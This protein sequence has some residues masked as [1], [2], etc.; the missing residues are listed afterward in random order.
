MCFKR[1]I[2]LNFLSLSNKI[3][4]L[5]FEIIAKANEDSAV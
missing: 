3:N 4:A 1:K 5:T 2:S